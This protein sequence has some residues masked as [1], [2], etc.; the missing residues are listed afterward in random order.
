MFNHLKK[1]WKIRQT[2]HYLKNNWH[3]FIDIILL[4]IVI[5]LTTNLLIIKNRK[6]PVDTT[7]INHL[8]QEQLSTSTDYI[9]IKTDLESSNF[10]AGETF[11]LDLKIENIFDKKIDNIVIV[12]ILE[13]KSFS[14]ASLKSE[15]VDDNF[16][17]DNN[18]II[19]KNIEGQKNIE[20]KIKLVVNTKNKKSRLAKLFFKGEYL[21]ENNNFY[22]QSEADALRLTASLKVLA[23]AYYHSRLGDQLGS[24]PIPPI[25][26]LPTNYWVF[27]ELDTSDN[28]LNNV[29]LNAK[30]PEGVT[31]AKGKTSTAGE[32]SYNES[33]RRITWSVKETTDSV[34]SYQ[35]GFELQI[36]PTEKQIGS[37]PLLLTN[38]SYL[39]IDSY[40][41]ESLSGKVPNIDTSLENDVINKDNGKVLE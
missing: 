17:I 29:T 38:I 28:I 22:F 2:K 12:P 13:D 41:K 8:E 16:I 10:K 1:W 11:S 24:G 31:L 18:K 30:L 40:T 20:K 21:I 9:V 32:I 25:S 39:A 35:A 6:Y 37:I 3:L 33:Q 34:K 36:I 15:E 19:I 14:L 5:F 26:G 4:L 23:N 27:F 7:P